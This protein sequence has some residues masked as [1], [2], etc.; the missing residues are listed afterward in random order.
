MGSNLYRL[1]YLGL[2]HR[3]ELVECDLQDLSQVIKIISGY[4]PGIFKPGGKLSFPIIPSNPLD[5]SVQYHSVLNILEA[6]RLINP[7]IRF[8][9]ASTMKCMAG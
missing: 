8:Y 9:Q 7:S 3:I 2:E 6:I 1:K 5:H 4:Q